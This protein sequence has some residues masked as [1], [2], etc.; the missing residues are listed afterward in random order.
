M[1]ALKRVD[2]FMD[3]LM[4]VFLWCCAAILIFDMLI[5][6]FDMV[7]TKLFGSSLG[8]ASTWAKYLNVPLVLFGTGAVQLAGSH[9]V[10]ELCYGSFPDGLKKVSYGFSLLLSAAVTAVLATLGFRYGMDLMAK[11]GLSNGSEGFFIWPFG[12]AMGLGWA[13]CCLASVWSLVRFFTGMQK[14]PGIGMKSVKEMQNA[15]NEAE[16]AAFDEAQRERE[17]EAAARQK[18]ASEEKK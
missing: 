13:L 9:T 11:G 18:G 6:F 16:I 3:R 5:L 7:I 8:Y 10:I 17:L 1:D 2:R 14:T 4:T 15:D 12:M